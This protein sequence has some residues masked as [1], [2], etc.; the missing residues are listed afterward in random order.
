MYFVET[1]YPPANCHYG[2]ICR[3]KYDAAARIIGSIIDADSTLQPSEDG[4]LAMHDK[5][6]FAQ[7]DGEVIAS[8]S[9]DGVQF[10]IIELQCQDTINLRL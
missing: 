1:Y 8:G 2:Y 7:T 10:R 3:T 6:S 4:I 9:I 5:T